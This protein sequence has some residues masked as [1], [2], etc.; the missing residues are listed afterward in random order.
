MT[1]S[2]INGLILI[3]CWENDR[4]RL[5]SNK[6]TKRYVLPKQRFFTG[7]VQ[8][9]KRFNFA[10]VINA[11]MYLTPSP[12]IPLG[13]EQKTSVIVQ[14]YLDQHSMVANVI[15]QSEFFELRKHMPWKKIN[16][17]LVVGTTWQICCHLNDIGLCSFSTMM[18]QH[19]K[20]N[21]YGAPWGFLKYNLEPTTDSDFETDLLSW[22]KF[23]NIFKLVRAVNGGLTTID[24]MTTIRNKYIDATPH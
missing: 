22:T 2:K 20:L 7:L 16:H 11:S 8:N 15:T 1:D 9:F 10:G 19:P 5:N 23:Y 14:E 6:N 3:D 4:I 21:F 24:P 13:K 17:W 18:L 12:N